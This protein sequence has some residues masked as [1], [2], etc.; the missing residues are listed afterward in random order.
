M[1]QPLSKPRPTKEKFQVRRDLLPPPPAANGTYGDA[2][3][4]QGGYNVPM[5]PLPPMYLPPPAYPQQL[6][7]E[8]HRYAPA[9]APA[10]HDR[11]RHIGGD[12]SSAFALPHLWHAFIS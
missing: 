11:Q 10:V 4:L 9:F 12:G 2:Q 8:Q 3:A 1:L 7:H 5:P 6:V